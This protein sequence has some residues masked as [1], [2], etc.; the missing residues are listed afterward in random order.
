VLRCRERNAI[1]APIKLEGPEP[2][3]FFRKATLQQFLT[4]GRKRYMGTPYKPVD[5]WDGSP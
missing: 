5:P 1:D 4:I 3:L 2:A